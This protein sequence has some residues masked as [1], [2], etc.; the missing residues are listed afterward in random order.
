MSLSA[1]GFHLRGDLTV[2]EELREV[3][4][5]GDTKSPVIRHVNRLLQTNA[6]RISEEAINQIEFLGERHGRR[7]ITLNSRA[8]TA[9]YEL[10][11]EIRYQVTGKDRQILFGP[12]TLLVERIYTFD[13]NSV[14]AKEAEESLLRK[15]MQ[16]SL[17]RQ[18]VHSYLSISRQ[19]QNSNPVQ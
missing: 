7:A 10:R 8:K 11:S 16:Q 14:N 17:A 18:V 3:K 9:E 5:K 12:E 15:E 13:E 19:Q 6:I 2:P 4:I 1:C